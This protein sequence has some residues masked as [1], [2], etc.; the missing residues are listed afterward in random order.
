MLLRSTTP[1]LETHEQLRGAL[2]DLDLRSLLE[3]AEACGLRGRGG[4]AFPF[5]TKLRTTA[6]TRGR[7]HV[8]VNLS[9][10]EPASAKD[11]VLT[12][13]QPHLVLDGACMAAHALRSGE[14]HVVTPAEHPES[15][16]AVVRALAERARAGRDGRLRWRLHLASP[17]FVA[18]ESS[19]VTELIDGRPNL[20][21]T[22]WQPT[23]VAGLSGRPTLLSNGETY[24]QLAALALGGTEVPGTPAEPGTRLLSI[25]ETT[26]TTR[27]VEVPHATPWRDVL[28][29]EELAAPVLL[30]GYHGTWAPP[31]ALT[32]LAV[33]HA[34]MT[35][36]GLGLG[37]GVVLPL[38]P[39]SCPLRTTAAIT[40]YLAGQS[41]GRCGP[42]R[43]GLPA[44]ATA[45][46]SFLAGGS[47]EKVERLRAL[48]V[49][50]GACAHPD[51]TVRLV[52]SALAAFPSEVAA[53]AAGE[54]GV[55]RP[56][57]TEV[58]S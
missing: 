26:G 5:A 13:H 40:R 29:A 24:A 28:T 36:A 52:A 15:R 39:E 47:L 34:E 57:L 54:C 20:P 16:D 32:H 42:C 10:G 14:V 50:R 58:T 21:V 19:A 2:P 12:L 51:G 27:V 22:S 56:T 30:G 25:G 9:E 46:D 44:L 35:A 23:A 1:D 55:R 17:R 4:A 3:I 18:G 8:V 41:A 33:S 31:G 45:L 49:G 43:N 6:A 7:R 48:V 53:H 37:A 38:G 11:L